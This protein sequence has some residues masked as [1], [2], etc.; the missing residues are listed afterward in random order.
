[1]SVYVNFYAEQN[2]PPSNINRDDTGNPKTTLYGGKLRARVSSQAQKRAMRLYFKDHFSDANLGVRTKQA[3]SLIADRMREKQPD[4]GDSADEFATMVL[5]ATGV[6]T[7]KSTRKGDAEGTIETPYL[8]F[9]AD[10]EL[11]GLADLAISWAQSGMTDK[12]AKKKPQK[13]QVAK[14]FHGSQA[15]D[16]ALFG[17]MLADAPDL[18]TDA[19]AQ[20]A[21]AISVDAITPDFDYY[22]A[23]D[24]ESPDDNAGAAMIG[25]VPFNSSTLYR[26]ADVDATALVDQLGSTQAAARAVSAFAEAFFRSMPTGKQNTFA[27]RTLPEVCFVTV[28]T[29]QPINLVDAFEKPVRA[30]D[31]ES[32]TEQAARLLGDHEA[33]VDEAY[34]VKPAAAYYVSVEGSVDSLDRVAQKLSFAQL[35]GQLEQQVSQQLESESTKAE[36]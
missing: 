6:T 35:T 31:D 4:L 16:I 5:E 12:D 15:V 20:V 8:I 33:G 13:D 1:M 11:D 18:N 29:D 36:D 26:Y 17:R 23:V 28:R 25:T 30:K 32:I 9:I 34:G 10:S 22:T 21:H 3:V 19:S 7:S 14:I 2:V 27:N 24:D